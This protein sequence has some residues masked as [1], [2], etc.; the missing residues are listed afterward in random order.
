MKGFYPAVESIL[1]EE[2][3]SVCYSERRLEYVQ[4]HRRRFPSPWGLD[5]NHMESLCSTAGW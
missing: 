2:G 1:Y 4:L 5:Y 3:C